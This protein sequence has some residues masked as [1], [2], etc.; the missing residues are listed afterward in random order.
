SWPGHGAEA[1]TGHFR[2]RAAVAFV[3][4]GAVVRFFLIFAVI[5]GSGRLGLVRCRRFGRRGDVVVRIDVATEDFGQTAALG[6]DALVFGEDAVHGAREVGD[7]AHHLAD[8]F[9]DALG[10]FDLAFAGQQFH[11]THFAHVHA[12]R[13]GGAAD[14]G[15]HRGQGS[16][17]FLGGGFVGLGFG[18][19]QGIGVRSGLED[20]DPHVVD[21]ADDVFHLF[22]VGNVLRQVVIDF[23]IGQ[24]ALL[25]TTA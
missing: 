16:G 15:L 6:G 1:L 18:E 19:Q 23:R 2:V 5:G 10:D 8:A 11:G 17:S 3:F 4:V 24:V 12:H 7:G 25:P 21:H 22:R 13:V 9:L 20:I 14:V